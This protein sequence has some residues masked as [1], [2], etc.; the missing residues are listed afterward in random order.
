MTSSITVEQVHTTEKGR[1]IVASL[2][3]QVA[4]DDDTPSLII[5]TL[6]AQFCEA[7]MPKN[8]LKV[9]YAID[10]DTGAVTGVC[11]FTQDD[12]QFHVLQI[13][14]LFVVEQYRRR[15]VASALIK[16]VENRAQTYARA[17]SEPSWHVMVIVSCTRANLHFWLAKQSYKFMR[18]ASNAEEQ[19]LFDAFLYASGDSNATN[20]FIADKAAELLNPADNN[21]VNDGDKDAFASFDTIVEFLSPYWRDVF[22]GTED[23]DGIDPLA[24][25]C[26]IKGDKF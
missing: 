25:I 14:G 24:C 26:A 5:E 9:L 7:S 15:G 16:E 23:A 11:T 19:R 22:N 17:H 3:E 2:L 1:S 20:A 13:I 21:S 18:T 6:T 4:L 10:S 12:A 8:I